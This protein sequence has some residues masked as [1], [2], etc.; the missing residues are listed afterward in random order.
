MS[1]LTWT[2]RASFPL[3]EGLPERIQERIRLVSASDWPGGFLIRDSFRECKWR[4]LVV[5]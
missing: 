3:P 4:Y 2:A 5:F 1:R